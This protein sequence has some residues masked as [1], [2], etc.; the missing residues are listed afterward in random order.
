M[1]QSNGAYNKLLDDY[2]ELQLR[3]TR[4]SAIQQDL[5]NTRDRLDHE[6]ELYKRLQNFTNQALQNIDESRFTEIILEHIIDILEV[7]A[8]IVYIKTREDQDCGRMFTEG[9]SVPPALAEEYLNCCLKIQDQIA[10][11]NALILDQKFFHQFPLAQHIHR[12]IGYKV[13][14]EEYDFACFLL[15]VIT[16]E[17]APIYPELEP[18]H[19]TIFEI[20]GSQV[21]SILSNRLHSERI[22]NSK[23][24]LQKLSL[25][26]T[27]TPNSVIITDQFGQV[28][29][30]NKAF[31]NTTGYS[32]E[33]TIGKKP[34]DFLQSDVT[35]QKER[36]ILSEALAKKQEVEV[37]IINTNKWGQP[38]YNQ[39]QITPVFNENGDH[40]NFIAVQK[41]ITK[42]IQYQRE[43]ERIKNFFESILAHAPAEIAVIDRYYQVLF[44]NR[45]QTNESTVL[46]FISGK[47]LEELVHANPEKN[48]WIFRLMEVIRT[49]EQSGEL[50]QYEEVEWRDGKEEHHYLLS[51]QPYFATEE[52]ESVDYFIVS[53]LEITDLKK[54]EK[55]IL[56]K[57]EELKKINSELDNFVYS[58]SHDLRSPLLS[59]KGILALIF[60]AY[61]VGEE[62]SKYLHLAESSINRL[63][64]T[65]QEILQYS[66]NARLEVK[67]ENFDLKELVQQIFEDIQFVT[68]APV[69][70]EIEIAGDP[71]ITADRARINT[72]IKN[73][74]SNAVKYRK[75]EIPNP[76]VRFEMKRTSRSLEM[77]VIDNGRGIPE[78]QTEKIFGM[79]FRGSAQSQGTG[80]GLYI[81]K[82]ILNKLGGQ[83]MVKSKLNEGTTMLFSLPLLAEKTT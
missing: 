58:V 78:D 28:E 73:L 50:Q 70:F 37:T 81:V 72:L 53:G 35:Q 74:A 64:G 48:E 7:E 10:P 41:D 42:E 47:S 38:Y 51:V 1:E 3:V 67:L 49:A 27:N 5:I 19:Q 52:S 18:R 14:N 25:I 68:P 75:T 4:F 45:N 57:N 39:L 66:R 20:F 23:Q 61:D 26:A 44:Y 80:L 56:K 15:G 36:K 29:W 77:K 54:I 46:D 34:K 11:Q 83:I 33:E 6:L 9:M 59:I 43:N 71:F 21:S 76:L 60:S 79:F 82:E 32:L 13:V 62:V 8:A 55:A 65:I 16:E 31:T 12:G 24:E 69:N 40:T 22:Q 63:D 30:V 17:N 2:R